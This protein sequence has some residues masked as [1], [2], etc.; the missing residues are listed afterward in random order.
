MIYGEKNMK[1][2]KLKY[3]PAIA[4]LANSGNNRICCHGTPFFTQQAR[5]SCR[6]TNRKYMELRNSKGRKSK[7]RLSCIRR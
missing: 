7:L 6:H 1:T 2:K 4:A 5:H 3:L